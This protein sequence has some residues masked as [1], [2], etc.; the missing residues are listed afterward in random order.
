M[1]VKGLF[2]NAIKQGVGSPA[3]VI[4]TA[5]A[6][7]ASYF[8]QLDIASLGPSGVQVDVLLTDADASGGP[9][10]T[11]IVENAPVPVGSAL[12]VIDNQKIVLEENDYISVE[13]KTPG[14]FV[15][16]TGSLIED[17]NS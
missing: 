1:A 8:I 2:K 14:A 10:T 9:V 12:S 13:C 4:Y 3:E 16:V 5:P 15:D 17:I 11:K 7:Y 6:G